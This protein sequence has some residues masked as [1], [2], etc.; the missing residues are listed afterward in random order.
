MQT[1]AVYGVLKTNTGMT[2]STWT[3][4]PTH[5]Q[6]QFNRTLSLKLPAALVQ[7]RPDTKAGHTARG[8]TVRTKCGAQFTF[9]AKATWLGSMPSPE[10]VSM[11]PLVSQRVTCSLE[12]QDTV[13]G[14]Q[15]WRNQPCED[16][17]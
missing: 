2:V 12:Y 5:Q 4:R 8:F 14:S 10:D 11:F 1:V 6:S 15:R 9:R 3:R 13:R 16:P 7:L 17:A